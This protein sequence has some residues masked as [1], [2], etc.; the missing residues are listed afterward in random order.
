MG[1]ITEII[2]LPNFEHPILVVRS[3]I[4]LKDDDKL[5]NP[6]SL[7]PDLL[8]ASVVYDNH[9]EYHAIK[10]DDVIGQLVVMKNKA[11]TFGIEHPT[12]STVELM[13]LVS[14][15]FIAVFCVD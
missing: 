6:Y 4:P 7:L 12:I 5:K 10:C 2:K 14:F 8:N 1:C 13:N 11:G 9:G 3:L 15:Q